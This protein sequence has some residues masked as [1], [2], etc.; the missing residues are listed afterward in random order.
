MRLDFNTVRALSSPTRIK[1]LDHV[2]TGESTPTTLSNDLDRSKSTVSSHLDKLVSAGLIEKDAEEGRK[3]VVYQPTDKAEAIVSG[4]EK[5]VKFS[6]TS[7]ALS[8]LGA[9]AVFG[10]EK[11]SLNSAS[12][13]AKETATSLSMEATSHGAQMAADAAASSQTMLDPSLIKFTGLGLL[14]VSGGLFL[15]G[16]LMSRFSGE[17]IKP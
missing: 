5:K 7:S 16:F 2:M 13:T 12:D 17:D 1:I 10:Y 8:L 4:R 14:A 11:I 3:R 6:I 9:A 15:Y